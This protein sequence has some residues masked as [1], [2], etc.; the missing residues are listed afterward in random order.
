MTGRIRPEAAGAPHVY[1]SIINKTPLSYRTNR[2]IGGVSPSQY[3]QR[4]QVGDSTTLGIEADKLDR[5]LTSH[6][7]NPDLLRAD[8]FEQFMEDRQR[9]LLGL[10]EQATGKSAYRGDMQ[11]EGVDV[12]SDADATEAGHTLVGVS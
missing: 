4:L 9:Q 10:I 5:Y 11:E 12:E 7:I 8:A 1:D 3:L 2:I 6:F